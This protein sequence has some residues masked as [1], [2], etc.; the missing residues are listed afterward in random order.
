MFEGRDI[1]IATKHS[2]EEVLGP[3][4]QKELGVRWMIP[5]NFDTDTLGTF[6][7]EVEREL[8]PLET[9]RLKCM[10]ALDI[11]GKD[12][13]IASEGSFG[14]H[15]T[16]FF[17]HADDE[18]LLLMDKKY[19][20]EIVARFL[21]TETNFNAMVVRSKKELID[22]AKATQ[23][24]SHGLIM[25]KSKEE[26][27]EMKKGIV[28]WDTLNQHFNF[29]MEKY[30]SAYVETDMR[31]MYNPSRMLFI[32]KVAHKLMAKVKSTCPDCQT[33]GL[34]I[35]AIKEGLPC[36]ACDLPTS[37]IVSYMY[38]CV[39]CAFVKEEMYP[40]GKKVEEPMFCNFCNP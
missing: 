33:P 30:L 37:S 7:G 4:L 6:S 29:L 12:L 10:K 24:P 17:S 31:A 9:A 13:A 36:S 21:T 11:T 2:K 23:F 35:T 38:S 5:A 27:N 39:R 32:E 40:N 34:G 18:L 28:D 19:E 14:P 1:V 20:L 8:D 15:P 22:F 25:K 26:F 3:L 16:I